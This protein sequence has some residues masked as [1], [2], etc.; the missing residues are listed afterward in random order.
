MA[1]K[2]RITRKQLLKEPDEFLTFSAKAIQFV[3]NNRRPVLGALIGVVVL[4]FAFAGFGYFSRLSERKAYAMFEE[5]RSHYSAQISGEKDPASLE[6]A[7]EKFEEVLRRYPSTDA[8]RLTLLSYADM[9]YQGRDYQKAVDLYQKA[10][11]A[12]SGDNAMQKLTWN[13]LAHA[14]EAK[15]AYEFA[16]EYF[17][18]ITDSQDNFMKGDAYYNLARM[19]EALNQQEKALEAYSRVVEA[20]PDSTGFQIAKDK[21]IQLKGIQETTEQPH[22]EG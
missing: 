22:S 7:T 13:G 20:H 1:K 17:K 14:Y 18:K 6:K 16:A 8:A 9:S 12:F 5:G 4:V 15:K 10:L 19:M 21:V 11:S 3:S 2:K